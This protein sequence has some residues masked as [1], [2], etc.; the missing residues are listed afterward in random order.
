MKTLSY[1]RVILNSFR[2]L[3]R[4]FLS[5]ASPSTVKTH[6]MS[7][8]VFALVAPECMFLHNLESSTNKHVYQYT[9]TD[10]KDNIVIRKKKICQHIVSS[11]PCNTH[12]P[13]TGLTKD[14]CAA[15]FI[16][17]HTS[18]FIPQLATSQKRDITLLSWRS[19]RG[20]HSFLVQE[21]QSSY[22]S[23]HI[24]LDEEKPPFCFEW[25]LQTCLQVICFQSYQYG[26]IVALPP[27]IVL[28]VYL[29]VSLGTETQICAA[30]FGCWGFHLRHPS[31]LEVQHRLR[32]R[33]A[34]TLSDV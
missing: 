27:R 17:V 25:R 6:C 16:F 18:Y 2:W 24:I 3:G 34:V 13:Y 28:G 15:E 14:R 11:G 12:R 21:S 30:V 10:I 7:V 23:C 4:F 1:C 31:A 9:K 20:I 29:S 33:R 32:E 8:K 22:N 19:S 5:T 26:G